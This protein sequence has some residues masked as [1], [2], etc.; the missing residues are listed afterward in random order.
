MSLHNFISHNTYIMIASIIDWSVLYWVDYSSKWAEIIEISESDFADIVSWISEIDPVSWEVVEVAPPTPSDAEL[1]ELKRQEMQSL[2]DLYYPLE[3]RLTYLSQWAL[4]T[5][6]TDFTTMNT[7][8]N[9]I[10]A[11]F[12]ANGKDADFTEWL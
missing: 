1:T 8:I 2:I 10:K 4:D 7:Y 3:K 11:E 9:G 5:A 6:D 12:V